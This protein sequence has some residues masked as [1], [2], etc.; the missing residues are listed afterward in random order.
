MPRASWDFIGNLKVICPP[1]GEQEEIVSAIEL[2]NSS[3]DVIISKI[4][5]EILLSEE[6]RTTL[7]A[8]AVTGKIDI[9]AYVIPDLAE[10]S[11]PALENEIEI[12]LADETEFETQENAE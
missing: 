8:E 5:K 4:E 12:D 6:Y 2:E 9:R 10:D 7:I 11:Y 3:T 1:V